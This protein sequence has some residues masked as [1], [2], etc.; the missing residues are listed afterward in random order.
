MGRTCPALLAEYAVAPV[1]M[2]VLVPLM[3]EVSTIDPPRSFMRGTAYLHD[4]Q[5]STEHQSPPCTMHEPTHFIVRNDPSRF[6]LMVSMNSDD[7]SSS[8]GAHV[9]FMPAFARTQSTCPDR[10][11]A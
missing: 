8:I 7:V 11:A 5:R 2:N 6:T 9:P 10:P 4:H 1:F 3:E